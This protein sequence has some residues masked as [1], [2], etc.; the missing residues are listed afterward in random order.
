MRRWAVTLAVLSGLLFV[1]IAIP[2]SPVIAWLTQLLRGKD[3][4]V[5]STPSGFEPGPV[6][7]PPEQDLRAAVG[8]M[9]SPQRTLLHYRGLFELLARRL[10]RRLVF[11]QRRTYA[12]TNELLASGEVHVAWVCTGAVPDLL[13][14]Q[15][16]ELAA[17]P[18]V[19]N[20]TTYRSYLVVPER[21]AVRTPAHLR[22]KIFAYTDPLSLTGRAVIERWLASRDLVPE[23]FFGSIFYTHAHDRSIQAVRRGLADAAC[24]DSLVY[25]FL[26][27][28]SPED[29]TG[30]SVIWHSEWFPIPP[31]VVSTR[32]GPSYRRRLVEILLSLGTDPEAQRILQEIGVDDFVAGRP[33]LYYDP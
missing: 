8:A 16:A 29:V 5:E 23:E 21:S 14:Q 27:A 25:D 9:I 31:L 1:A 19:E 33:E 15:T 13:A 30:T 28:R 26:A 6:A 17:V 24:V 22:G 32:L 2:G 7:T 18:V 12:E 11:I 3:V 20:R 10:D 4:G